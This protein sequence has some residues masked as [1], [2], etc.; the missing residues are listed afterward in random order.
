ML[1]LPP[2]GVD[3]HAEEPYA[4][5]R[6]SLDTHPLPQWWHDAKFGIF[7][8]WAFDGRTGVRIG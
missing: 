1:T 2:A 3:L 8:H 4:P 7:I 6:Q 5:T